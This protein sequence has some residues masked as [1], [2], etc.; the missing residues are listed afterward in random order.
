MKLIKELENELIAQ[1]NLCKSEIN[2][3][4][5]KCIKIENGYKI[6][7][8]IKCENCKTVDSFIMNYD[9]MLKKYNSKEKH[10]NQLY[11]DQVKKDSIQKEVEITKSMIKCPNC[12]SKNVKRIG[13]TNKIS[14]FALFGIFSIGKVIKSYECK[15][16]K[17]KW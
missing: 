11:F 15:D 4:K 5:S 3:D 17:Y 10:K 13:M 14:S 7:E 6:N 16:C 1:C 2:I 9:F 12:R 8:I